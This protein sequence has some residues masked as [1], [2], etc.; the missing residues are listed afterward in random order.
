MALNTELHKIERNQYFNPEQVYSS[1]GR[2]L[3]LNLW[4][5][6]FMIICNFLISKIMGFDEVHLKMDGDFID[7]NV[8]QC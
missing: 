4:Y 8:G 6:M 7:I 2:D 3:I 5:C 1:W